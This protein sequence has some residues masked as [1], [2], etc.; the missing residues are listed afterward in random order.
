MPTNEVSPNKPNLSKP[1]S[2][3]AIWLRSKSE[4]GPVN[5]GISPAQHPLSSDDYPDYEVAELLANTDA[6]D[7]SSAV[8]CQPAYA[9][10][11]GEPAK[12]D[13]SV[14][15]EDTFE[16]PPTTPPLPKMSLG[17]S[18]ERKRAYPDSMQAPP[19]RN[20]SRKTLSEKSAQEVSGLV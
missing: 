17:P 14:T 20:V 10:R 3:P 15:S 6:M 7:T 11:A 1:Q 4:P 16:T 2:S 19:S 12:I 9:R 13:Q 18:T 8:P 5:R